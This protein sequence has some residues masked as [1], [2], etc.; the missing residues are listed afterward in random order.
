MKNI[1]ASVCLCLATESS[2]L[3]DVEVMGTRVFPGSFGPCFLFS[4]SLVPLVVQNV[5]QL[6]LLKGDLRKGK[7]MSLVCL[8]ANIIVSMGEGCYTESELSLKPI[9]F[10]HILVSLGALGV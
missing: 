4:W 8:T 10:C 3:K 2:A 9:V 6:L 7:F 1:L 5:R